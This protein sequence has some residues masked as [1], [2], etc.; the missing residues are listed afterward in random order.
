MSNTWTSRWQAQPR[1]NRMLILAML[2]GLL[3]ALLYSIGVWQSEEPETQTP[4]TAAPAPPDTSLLA[5]SDTF[6]AAP[7]VLPQYQGY[8]WQ[9]KF[10]TVDSM[11]RTLLQTLKENNEQ[12]YLKTLP[13]P[14]DIYA[15]YAHSGMTP[16]EAEGMTQQ[17]R[18]VYDQM[19]DN[20]RT[21]F[22]KL[23]KTGQERGINWATAT[24]LRQEHQLTR[25][26]NIPIAREVTI[27]FTQGGRQWRFR[28][29]R[30]MKT[31][32]GW[33]G[34]RMVPELEP[35]EQPG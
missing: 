14:D 23:Y 28:L 27:Y 13:T 26:A 29:P 5:R 18:N 32:G 1:L 16:G 35:V 19:M 6:I 33:Q 8:R 2:V 34:A 9:R 20:A 11:A 12:A 7:S 24:Y 15:T 10:P 25:E 30:A 4:K 22:R 21:V 31:P 17:I 3:G